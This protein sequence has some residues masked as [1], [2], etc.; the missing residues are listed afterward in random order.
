M[1]PFSLRGK[2]SLHQMWSVKLEWSQAIPDAA[3]R[4][5]QRWTDEI[6]VFG[7]FEIP[8]QYFTPDKALLSCCLH[9]FW[10][11]LTR[12]IGRS[13]ICVVQV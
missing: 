4:E 13:S 12:C 9:L 6:K 1:L 8:R 3:Q 10:R 7:E 5:L 11:C 2:Q